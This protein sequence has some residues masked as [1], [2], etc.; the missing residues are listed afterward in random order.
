MKTFCLFRQLKWKWKYTFEK[1][2]EVIISFVIGWQ[3]VRFNLETTTRF[4]GSSFISSFSPNHS[5]SIRCVSNTAA[6]KKHNR[7]CMGQVGKALTEWLIW[8]DKV[9]ELWCFTASSFQRL[10][11]F[12]S[13]SLL[14]TSVSLHQPTLKHSCMY[15]Y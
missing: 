9:L 10:Y 6:G 13:F 1:I 14:P 15:L 12:L 11:F 8:L 3:N 7:C 5:M 4:S 2:E